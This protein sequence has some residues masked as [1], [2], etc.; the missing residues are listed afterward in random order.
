MNTDI[1]EIIKKSL[2]SSISYDEFTELMSTLAQNEGTT[3]AEKTEALVNYTKLNDRRVK[4]W[5]KT[6][7]LSD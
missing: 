3:G 1:T 6:V 5:N 7:K 2:Q 4:R